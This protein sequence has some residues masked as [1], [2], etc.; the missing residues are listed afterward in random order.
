MNF[1][2]ESKGTPDVIL[3]IVN[4]HEIELMNSFQNLNP[5]TILI[6]ENNLKSNLLINFKKGENFSA[7]LNFKECI[8]SDFNKCEIN[9]YFPKIVKNLIFKSL[10]HELTHL[11]E[12]YQIKDF[13]S[14]TK[15]KR[16]EALNDTKFQN[17]NPSL[18]YFKD[19]FYLSLPHEVNARVSSL[20]KY[21]FDT[22]IK[23]KD[24]LEKILITTIEWK[25]MLNLKNFSYKDCY[26]DLI[27][28]YKNKQLLYDIFN[29]FNLKMKIKTKINSDM[30][31][32]NYLKN[33]N[34]YFKKVSKNF[35]NKLLKILNR[36]LEDRINEGYLIENFKIVDYDQYIKEYKKQNKDI[37]YL[38]FYKN[39]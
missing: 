27:E 15:W 10:I 35:K 13:Y 20:Y 2:L 36:V 3:N 22:K 32:F 8:D 16:T 5:I 38:D 29:L 12:L 17:I 28:K 23:E 19:I 34:K 33:S 21:L 14:E 24:E 7:S 37:N 1:I 9:L 18:Q 25:N 6:N 11:Y 4:N 30:D 26:N 39:N 31:L